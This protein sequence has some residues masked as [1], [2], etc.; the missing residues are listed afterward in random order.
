MTN[1]VDTEG[2]K[3]KAT[4][5]YFFSSKSELEKKLTFRL[6]AYKSEEDR[7]ANLAANISVPLLLLLQV[8]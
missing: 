4:T 1:R 7:N 2:Y 5:N 8:D 6:L 3:H